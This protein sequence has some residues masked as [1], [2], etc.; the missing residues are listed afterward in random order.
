VP[1]LEAEIKRYQSTG[2]IL[3]IVIIAV[4]TYKSLAHFSNHAKLKTKAN[5]SISQTIFNQTLG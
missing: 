5:V 4:E 1:Y 3:N 2:Y